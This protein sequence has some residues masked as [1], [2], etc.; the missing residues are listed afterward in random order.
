MSQQVLLLHR[1]DAMI[2]ST[3]NVIYN[4]QFWVRNKFF[5]QIDIDAT[6]CVCLFVWYT[7]T[8]QHVLE[9][10]DIPLLV[11]NIQYILR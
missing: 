5:L 6:W 9:V 8:T 10:E 7:P 3:Y 11:F 4:L 2:H 1:K